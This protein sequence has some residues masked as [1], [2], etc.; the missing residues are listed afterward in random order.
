MRPGHALGIELLERVRLLSHADILDRLFGNTIDRQR[1]AAARIA[2]HLR[3]N[4]TGDVEPR[5]EA[6][7]DLHGILARHAVGD[8]EDLVGMDR[9]LE[10]LELLHHVVVDLQSTGGID[11]DHAIA[12]AL[13]LF[14]AGLGNSHDVL[15][16][17]LGVD[18][19]IELCAER[20]ELIDGRRSVDVAGDKTRRP[21][22]RP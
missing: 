5:V 4:Y 9:R 17:A 19:H 8:E 16:I 14:D 1:R 3:E 10:T 2:V 15:R 22:L 20:L 18:G 11:D 6:L 7:R 21:I 12:R 13:R